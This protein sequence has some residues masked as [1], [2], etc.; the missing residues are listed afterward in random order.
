MKSSDITENSFGHLVP[1]IE[2]QLA[3]VPNDLP[4]KMK[5]TGELVTTLS[6]A[7][8]AIGQLHGVGLNLPNPNL[9]ITPFLRREAEMSSRIE[10]TQAQVQDIYLFEL[11]E[12]AI[13]P[14]IPDVREVANYVRALEH[15]LSR[16][17]ELPVCL[18]LIRELHQILLEGV[19]GEQD[20][21]G[22][23][24]NTQNWIG[25]PGSPIEQATFIPPPP[26]HIPAAVD[27][28]EKF[29]NLPLVNV[30]VLVWL[31]MV[32]YQFESIHPFRD[33]N[34][35]IGRLLITLLLCTKGVLDKPLLYLSDYFERNRQ[36]YYERLLRVSTHGQW[37]EWI[38]FFLRGIVE[39]ALDAFERS[40]QLLNLHQQFISLVKAKRSALQLRIVDLLIERPVITTVLVS[41]HFNVTY[42]TAKNNINK[43]VELGVLHELSAAKQHTYIADKVLNVINKPVSRG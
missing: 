6:D 20:R 2:D 22:E 16:C 33:G 27:A 41:K 40:R 29:V 17:R 37:T 4:P 31:A 19:R 25:S 8:R 23:L 24:R 12:P 43:L 15:G 39:Q 9:L 11:R 42:P 32:H 1:T 18:R 30:P 34:G 21:P 7:D 36:Q 13:E 5:W 26:Q 3:F 10:G 28:F 38:L 35:R 14:R